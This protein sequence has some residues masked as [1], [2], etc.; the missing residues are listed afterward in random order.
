MGIPKFF[1][2]I[3][4]RYPLINIPFPSTPPQLDNLY[5]DMN[6]IIHNCARSSPSTTQ[7]SKRYGPEPATTAR[8]SQ[9][10][11]LDVFKYIDNL[12]SLAKPRRVLYL[13]VDGVA[14]RAKMNQQRSR[15]FRSARERADEHDKKL[16]EDVI[17]KA[18]N[19][20]PFDSNCITPGT[21][22]M[23]SLTQS[24][25]Y[26]VARKMSEDPLWMSLD[27][28]V[29]SGPE[30]PG[31]GEHKIMEYIRCMRESG[32]LDS[33]TRHCVYGLDADLIMLA[34]VTHEPHFFLL[35][36]KIDFTSFWKKKGGGPRI[37]TS[38]D[39]ASFGEFELMSIG[40]LREYIVLELGADFNDRLPYFDIERLFDDFVFMLMLIGNDFLPTLP[41]LDIADGTLSVMLHLYKRLLPLMGGFLTDSGKIC[42]GR[43]E[44][45]VAKLA[46]IEYE[47]LKHKKDNQQSSNNN[48]DG[49]RRRRGGARSLACSPSDLDELFALYAPDS[50]SELSQSLTA[51]ELRREFLSCSSMLAQ[52]IELATLKREYYI[53][54]FG[55]Q[56]LHPN[57]TFSDHNNINTVGE[58]GLTDLASNYVEGVSW[59]LKYY[60][61][62][63]RRWH[64][65][66]PFHYS[67]LAS[68]ITTAISVT[69]VLKNW[70]N[71]I[72]R[73]EP[74][75]PWQ[76]LLSVLPQP[77]AW[78]LPKAYRSLM[79]S[80]SSPLRNYFPDDFE[81]DLNGKRNDWEAVVLLP[82]VDEKALLN[83]MHCIPMDKISE[84][85][86]IQ[87]VPG[88]SLSFKVLTTINA[89]SNGP[90]ETVES[91]FPNRLASFVSKARSAP[92]VLPELE[93]GTPFSSD[94]L[95]GTLPALLLLDLP[96]LKQLKFESTQL[97]HV[98][99][100]VFGTSSRGDSM[101]LKLSSNPFESRSSSSDNSGGMNGRRVN[102]EYDTNDVDAALSERFELMQARNGSGG[103][104]E[105]E[106]TALLSKR[107]VNI[108]FPAWFGFPW[109]KSCSVQS[110]MT[111]LTTYSI[112]GGI[113]ISRPTISSNFMQAASA[114]SSTLLQKSAIEVDKPNIVIGIRQEGGNNNSGKESSSNSK[115]HHKDKDKDEN[116]ISFQHE[117]LVSERFAASRWD[118]VGSEFD[119]HKA[120]ASLSNSS[121]L[122]L[123]KGQTVLYVGHGAY[124]G[125]LC[126]I[127]ST[128]LNGSVVKVKFKSAV[129]AAREP[130]FGY[131]V[132]SASNAQRWLSLSRLATELG[133]SF[134]VVDAFLGSL[135]IRLGREREEVD[136][137]IGVKYK[138]R[139]LYVPGYARRD[140]RH[141]YSFSDRCAQLLRKYSRAFPI[142][143]AGIARLTGGRGHSG[144]GAGT[145]GVVYSAEDVLQGVPGGAVAEALK[146]VQS[147]LSVQEVAN[148]PLVHARS[149]VLPKD[150]VRELERHS[151]IMSHL[152]DGFEGTLKGSDA[153]KLTK[154]V[155]RITIL[156]GRE[157]LNFNN[158]PDLSP[159]GTSGL[160]LPNPQQYG[161][162]EG[163]N[164]ATSHHAGGMPL[165]FDPVPASA[166][167][168][169]LGDRVVNR[170]A[171]SGVPFGLRGSVVGVH[172]STDSNDQQTQHGGHG[173]S[174][175]AT[176]I[177]S[178]GADVAYVEV[179]FDEGFI[180]GGS[181]DG[182]CSEG[183][184]KAVAAHSLFIIRPERDNV[185]Y[186]RQYARITFKLN[187]TDSDGNGGEDEKSEEA[188]AMAAL[189]L[190]NNAC[191]GTKRLDRIKQETVLKEEGI[192]KEEV[193]V[194]EEFELVEL[195]QVKEM[196]VLEE[197][198]VEE[199][200]EMEGQEKTEIEIETEGE[201]ETKSLLLGSQPREISM[202]QSRAA[203]AK[204]DV[205]GRGGGG[206]VKELAA[207][208]TE[209]EEKKEAA[210]VAEAEAK[211]QSAWLVEAEAKTKRKEKERV[212]NIAAAKCKTS[213]K[214]KSRAD[215][216]PWAVE[217]RLVA[218]DETPLPLP[219]FLKR[220][221]GNGLPGGG[222]GGGVVGGHVSS[223][224]RG[225]FGGSEP[226]LPGTS[227]KYSS[228]SGSG[229]RIGG[230]RGAR[231]GGE[232]R[233]QQGGRSRREQRQVIR[234][235]GQHGYGRGPGH[236]PGHEKELETETEQVEEDSEKAK[237]AAILAKALLRQM[238]V[239]EDDADKI[240]NASMTPSASTS[241][242]SG[243]GGKKDDKRGG[244]NTGIGNVKRHGSGNVGND[245]D[246]YVTRWLQLQDE[247]VADT[248][249]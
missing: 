229:S 133:M 58:D 22:F 218:K 115:H 146:A 234:N 187:S 48:S 154:E 175:N 240:G 139:A 135:R 162:A 23:H 79:T 247:A 171:G 75:L 42:A 219:S 35:R 15:R 5:L 8:T 170:L 206:V 221:G 37:A 70:E 105:I 121:D 124:F 185:Y 158:V 204:Y 27:S 106:A 180:G 28:V 249:K 107:G 2:F 123:N 212:D 128:A 68:D 52:N 63:C 18:A 241:A 174:S 110:V 164:F 71:G 50:A 20:D 210:W 130:P 86:R 4:E 155:T 200:I 65:F 190:F 26:F 235:Q 82:F 122:T 151:K 83:A 227:L 148:V 186:S 14:P 39:L 60:I 228:G 224:P 214:G 143:F 103:S 29:L 1:R 179:L 225:R 217:Y 76:Q 226:E 54:K 232:G 104:G 216:T 91:P 248:K 78:C 77:S 112:E 230:G 153:T 111:P 108:G 129:G 150:A 134:A 24:L 167:G 120:L 73:D 183:R 223:S 32:R 11:Y 7:S 43:F 41:T 211:K 114:V 36:E 80:A 196:D 44:F 10:I 81:T 192:L 113:T 94:V 72:E 237:E 173:N 101:V 243:A 12:V 45:F 182:R 163:W 238:S 222:R 177:G 138:A 74:F 127:V 13:A 231:K 93:D 195:Q 51:E 220:K 97:L 169:R 55:K 149:D 25:R 203:V 30:S 84:E 64:W 117:F 178:G 49:H 145:G 125:H 198:G 181:L 59:T 242:A 137:G 161:Q 126:T 116:E 140:D 147:W 176:D 194:K 118:D 157:G 61:E 96:S 166:A 199:D 209:A 172:P 100:N 16:R 159:S 3:S 66:F 17:Y 99:V 62:G 38:L 236:G 46:M 89:A 34:L 160:A 201:K 6:G 136:V 31:E 98:G 21:P 246:E 57:R 156:T 244:R 184:G 245:D 92:L 207:A 239:T 88:P 109:R 144:G 53:G 202:I 168:L 152:R 132:V 191:N 102:D 141:Y 40:V 69:S 165:H 142:L 33:N 47:V 131:R 19:I 193:V 87:N 188:V 208:V 56:F 215:G 213:V 119:P 189:D 233:Q 67:P 205:V 197:G 90:E 9:D 95:D 85:E